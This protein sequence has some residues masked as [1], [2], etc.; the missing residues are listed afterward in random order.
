M[1]SPLLARL[2]W[3]SSSRLPGNPSVPSALRAV[4]V[5]LSAVSGVGSIAN[6]LLRKPCSPLCRQLPFSLG[7]TCTI[8][9]YRGN[10]APPMRL[11]KRPTAAPMLSPFSS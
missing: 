3:I 11:A 6:R 4:S 5:T 10:C 8:F 2:Y 7:V 1:T 9:S